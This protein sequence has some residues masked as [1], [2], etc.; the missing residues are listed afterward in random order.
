MHI[1]HAHATIY[2]PMKSVNCSFAVE[3]MYAVKDAIYMYMYVV[4]SFNVQYMC[5]DLTD[6]VF[7]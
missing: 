2:V 4:T 1:V 5:L 6:N 3:Y 7:F